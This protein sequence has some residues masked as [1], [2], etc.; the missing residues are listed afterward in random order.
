MLFWKKHTISMEEFKIDS[1][2]Y[3]AIQ[4]TIVDSNSIVWTY[5]IPVG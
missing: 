5:L 1:L 3:S 2:S 4:T